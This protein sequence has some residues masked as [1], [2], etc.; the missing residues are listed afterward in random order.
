[1]TRTI[2]IPLDTSTNAGLPVDYA[3]AILR[4]TGGRLILYSVIPDEALRHHM[5]HQLARVAERAE[6]TGINVTSRIEYQ[7]GVATAI[8]DNARAD[9]ADLIAMATSA[10]SDVGRWL[11]DSVADEVLRRAEVPVLIVP[12]AA[13]QTV[14]G[15]TQRIGAQRQ[16][17]L[18]RGPAW[19]SPSEQ[20]PRI[21]VPLNGSDLAQQALEPA[22]ALA[23]DMKAGLLLLRVVERPGWRPPV[24]SHGDEPEWARAQLSEAQQYLD[25]VATT[26]S[27]T[28]GLVTTLTVVG[29]PAAE[30]AEAARTHHAHLIAMA[31]RGR[32]G[33]SRQLLGSVATA[34]LQQAS[35]P[36]L[37]VRAKAT[38]T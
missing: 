30:I 32:S 20:P 13:G 22:R 9:G 21:L 11:R 7:T 38:S 18:T 29:D 4:A 16:Q 23:A 34:T 6:Q 10:S 33:L 24:D 2:L 5:E 28:D 35:I 1:M 36:V 17:A 31:T 19:P 8:I 25:G 27:A 14:I 26:I 3:M 12:V 37:I 15:M